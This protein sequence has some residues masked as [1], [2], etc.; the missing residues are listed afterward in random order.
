V[1]VGREGACSGW[2]RHGELRI[3][4]MLMDDKKRNSDHDS[5]R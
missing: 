2:H 5:T 1:V 3:V 4:Y